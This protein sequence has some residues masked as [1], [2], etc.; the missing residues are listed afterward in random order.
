M[1]SFKIDHYLDDETLENVDSSDSSDAE[2]FRLVTI[3]ANSGSGKLRTK[4]NPDSS[5]LPK[6]RLAL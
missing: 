2:E 4:P 3:D 6:Q 1:V 5:N